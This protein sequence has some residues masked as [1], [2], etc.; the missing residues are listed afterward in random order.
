MLKERIKNQQSVSDS[1][2]KDDSAV[3]IPS[4]SHLANFCA[5]IKATSLSARNRQLP[6]PR[7]G[8]S[9]RSQRPSPEATGILQVLCVTF[10][11]DN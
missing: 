10:A 2:R 7:R 6:L 9:E 4:L 11:Y 5:E 3:F 1:Y 8:I